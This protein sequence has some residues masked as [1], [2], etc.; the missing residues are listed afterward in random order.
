MLGHRGTPIATRRRP[1]DTRNPH[2]DNTTAAS[3][4]GWVLPDDLGLEA[5]PLHA[6]YLLGCAIPRQSEIGNVR[7][8][9]IATDDGLTANP[10]FRGIADMD[11][12]SLRNDV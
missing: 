8:W 7:Y 10:R 11:R 6:T 9:P 3:G 4:F 2:V 1:L 12:F 5:S